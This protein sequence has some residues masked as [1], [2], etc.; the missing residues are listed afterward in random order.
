MARVRSRMPESF[1]ALRGSLF[2]GYNAEMEAVHRKNAAR[3]REIMWAAGQTCM[4]RVKD[5]TRL[6]V[7]RESWSRWRDRGA[8][9]RPRSATVFRGTPL[10]A[11][12]DTRTRV[13]RLGR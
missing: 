4:G 2:D 7:T 6:T 3:L 12:A 5:L 11:K 9:V 1:T 13:A 10:S 8:A